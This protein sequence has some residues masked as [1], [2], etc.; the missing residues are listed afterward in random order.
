MIGSLWLRV[1]LTG[2]RDCDRHC[3]NRSRRIDEQTTAEWIRT[4]FSTEFAAIS[5]R[6]VYDAYRE[7]TVQVIRPERALL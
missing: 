5:Q 1:R 3:E 7:A 2:S 6:M 4:V